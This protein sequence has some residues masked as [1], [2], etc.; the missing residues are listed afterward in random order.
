MRLEA[1][2]SLARRAEFDLAP[3]APLYPSRPIPVGGEARGFG[4]FAPGRP[5]DGDRP[6]QSSG[7]E[8]GQEQEHGAPLQEVQREP[9]LSTQLRIELDT[10]AQRYVYSHFVPPDEEPVFQFPS[11]QQLA[12]SR[13]LNAALRAARLA[14]ETTPSIDLTV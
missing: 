11:E 4:R 12:F 9:K 6:G 13:A 8:P 2:L 5:V 7:Q 10:L 1:Q 14:G 3:L